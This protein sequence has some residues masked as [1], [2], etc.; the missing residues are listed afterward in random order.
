[1]K[2]KEIVWIK[3]ENTEDSELKCTEHCYYQRNEGMED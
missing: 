1:M 2:K 3:E